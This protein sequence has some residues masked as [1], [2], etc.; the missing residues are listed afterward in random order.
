MIVPHKTLCYGDSQ[1]PPEESIPM[2]TLRNFPNLMEHCIEWGRD[3]FNSMFTDRAQD[4]LNFIENPT[5]F[6]NGLK[7][8][9]TSSG[10]KEKLEEIGKIL[11][12][13]L[14]ADF[15]QCV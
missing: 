13:K 3:H 1:D 10:A 14:S 8:N 11:K 5:A 6:L 4:A 15:S 9:T 12:L 2:C 7:Q